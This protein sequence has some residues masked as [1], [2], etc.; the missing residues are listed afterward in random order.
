MQIGDEVSIDFNALSLPPLPAG[1]RRDFLIYSEGWVKDGDLNTANGQTVA[2]LPFH[3]MPSY[4]YRN[5]VAYPDDK[6]HREYQQ[7]YNT[8]RVNTDDFKNALKPKKQQEQ[9]KQLSR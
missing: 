1:W 7:R 8:R 5:N 4:P 6:E 3:N 2:P 9:N